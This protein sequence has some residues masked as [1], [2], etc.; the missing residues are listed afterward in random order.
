MAIVRKVNGQLDKDAGAK[1]KD[2]RGKT[3]V[4]V[5]DHG[6]AEAFEA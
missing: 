5:M 3:A 4:A 1:L 6:V 2:M